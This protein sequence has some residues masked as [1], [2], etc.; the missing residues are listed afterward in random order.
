[1]ARTIMY[2]WKIS[3]E[4]G[5]E[6]LHTSSVLSYLLFPEEDEGLFREKRELFPEGK[7][8]SSSSSE[9][10]LFP[11]EEPERVDLVCL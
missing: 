10:E 8:L 6:P 2:R 3:R 1:M 11:E 9:E 4:G 5:A 7:E